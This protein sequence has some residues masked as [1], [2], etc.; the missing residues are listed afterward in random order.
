[1]PL[2]RV[3]PL[4]VIELMVCGVAI[5]LLP[6]SITIVSPAVTFEGSEGVR[7]VVPQ[8]ALVAWFI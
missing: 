1:L 6:K 4:S 7:V 8:V 3:H 5:A 2:L